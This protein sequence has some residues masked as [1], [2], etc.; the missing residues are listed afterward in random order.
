MKTTSLALVSTALLLAGCATCKQPVT[1]A[2]LPETAP[3]AAATPPSAPDPER[4][5]LDELLRRAA[6]AP[7]GS[8]G[9]EDWNLLFNGRDLAPWHVTQFA[10]GGE[11]KVENGLLVLGMG[12]PFTGIG[13]SNPPVTMNYEIALEAMRVGGWDFFCALTF[14]VDTNHCSLIVGGWGGGV[15]GISSIDGYDAS[16][17]ET[18]KFLEFDR[19]RWYRI[20]VRVTEKKLEAWLDDRKVI[21]VQTEDR[22]ISVR[23]GDI[24]QCLPLGIASYSTTAALR[25]LRWRAVSGPD[26]VK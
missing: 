18:T 11:V 10:G 17:N 19:G 9:G 3:A 16:E 7:L 26:S 22:R 6:A 20:R 23:G 12:G 8:F 13:L 25:G 24:E 21:N 5:G 14:P 2:P 4:V 15:V 1:F